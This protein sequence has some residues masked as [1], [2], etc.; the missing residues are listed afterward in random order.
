[1]ELRLAPGLWTLEAERNGTPWTSLGPFLLEPPGRDLG[2]LAPAAPASLVCRVRDAGGRPVAA[3]RLRLEAP[4]RP[5][6]EAV[7]G[8]DGSARF[9]SLGP[10][11]YVLEA[12]PF[13]G[14]LLPLPALRQELFLAPGV[15]A[16]RDLLLPAPAGARLEVLL[17]G[18]LPASALG[19]AWTPSTLA[20][21][22][23]PEP[24][25]FV[26]PRLPELEGIGCAASL[27]TGF[28]L[29]TA[30]AP[31]G[32]QAE[33][34]PSQATERILEI[35]TAEGRPWTEGAVALRFA[36]GLLPLRARPDRDGRLRLRVHTAAP[37]ELEF[38]AGG[39]RV[40]ALPLASAL[41]AGELVLPSPPPGGGR[42]LDLRGQPLAGAAVQDLETG[43]T[44]W[45]GTAGELPA[46]RLRPGGRYRARKSGY[47]DRE[48]GAAELRQGLRLRRILRGLR[49]EAPPGEERIASLRF[50][51]AFEQE[52]FVAPVE[53]QRDA[54]LGAWQADLP[55]GPWRLLLLD[56]NGVLLL[57]TDFR[58]E[59]SPASVYPL[60]RP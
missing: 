58:A 4:G 14:R 2:E 36:G 20:C 42:V 5:P 3:L 6:R 49:F 47:L 35:R 12:D 48:G 29:L 17:L 37:A 26:L 38:L 40:H 11:R 46:L 28:L 16:E 27:G 22:H 10:G 44:D 15:A 57:E 19:F 50:L 32:G 33:L 39:R 7:T 51:P 53:A 43:E 45:S 25:R 23:L 21:L 52:P 9:E 1:M 56:R 8:E 30:P 24:E 59:P 31:G 54:R 55:E 18:G 60:P 41:G 13:Q 34:D